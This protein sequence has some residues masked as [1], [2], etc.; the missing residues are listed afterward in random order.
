MTRRSGLLVGLLLASVPTL[1]GQEP[2]ASAE[3]PPAP[4][5]GGSATDVRALVGAPAGA[6][7]TGPSLDARTREVGALLRCPVCQ[8][9]SVADSPSSMA[10]DMKGQVRALLAEGYSQEQILAYFERSYGEF[11]RLQPTFSGA[12]WAVWLAPAAALG[13]GL[14]L[15]ARQLRARARASA[16]GES[17]PGPGTAAVAGEPDAGPDALPDDP[18]RARYVLRVRELAYGWPGGRP[19]RKEP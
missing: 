10:Q 2:P 15:V 7:L 5:S 8:G 4:R 9:L 11:V 1:R 18:E 12:N 3:A 13:L 14:L 6:P 19:P 17:A 16:S